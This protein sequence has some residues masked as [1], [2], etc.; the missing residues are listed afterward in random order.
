MSKSSVET[1]LEMVGIGKWNALIDEPRLNKFYEELTSGSPLRLAIYCEDA[2]ENIDVISSPIKQFFEKFEFYESEF[3]D[4]LS[5]D[6]IKILNF[7]ASNTSLTPEDF[8]AQINPLF[9]AARVIQDLE[10]K[11]IDSVYM[12]VIL[13]SY[14]DIY[15]L[16][17]FQIDRRLREHLLK[18]GKET[19]PKDIFYPRQMNLFFG[20]KGTN[21]ESAKGLNKIFSGL[22]VITIDNSSMIHPQSKTTKIRNNIC[23]AGISHIPET[24]ELIHSGNIVCSID[25]FETELKRIFIFLLEWLALSVPVAERSKD[26]TDIYSIIDPAVQKSKEDLK[27]SYLQWSKFLRLLDKDPKFK[28][29]Y[30][31]GIKQLKNG[32]MKIARF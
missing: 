21:H 4:Y 26:N 6:D 23:H 11:K 16:S 18:I 10:K 9:S 7:L 14:V 17:L 5:E 15:E 12:T 22:G 1:L 19:L 25:E 24:M 32:K 3:H 29:Q 28:K 13:K 8:L 30:V 31:Q 20:R 27:E 2:A